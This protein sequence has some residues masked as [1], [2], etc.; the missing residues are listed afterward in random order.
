MTNQISI[1]DF[2]P[3]SERIEL[4]EAIPA[5]IIEE[6]PVVEWLVTASFTCAGY[7]VIEAKTKEEAKER[8]E[9]IRRARGAGIYWDDYDSFD[10]DGIESIERHV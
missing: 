4:T 6:L 3:E 1:N 10:F 7:T 2:L 8:V 9:E 5:S